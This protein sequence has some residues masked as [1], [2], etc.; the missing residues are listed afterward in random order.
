MQPVRERHLH[1]NGPL[2]P[3]TRAAFNNIKRDQN[4]P[5]INRRPP[6]PPNNHACVRSNLNS[7]PALSQ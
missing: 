6:L 3:T 1:D 5:P 7:P 4:V 2:D